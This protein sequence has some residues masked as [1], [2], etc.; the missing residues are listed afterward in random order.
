MSVH[1]KSERCS[2]FIGAEFCSSVVR[3]FSSVVCPFLVKLW[4]LGK[5]SL[6]PPK[7]AHQKEILAPF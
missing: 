3:V 5:N 1:S 2:L 6:A 7:A 4:G